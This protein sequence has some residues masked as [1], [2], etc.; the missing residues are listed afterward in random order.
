MAPF[1]FRFLQLA[2]LAACLS[3]PTRTQESICST[4]PELQVLDRS[5]FSFSCSINE[6]IH[7]L[8]CSGRGV[9]A[10]PQTSDSAVPAGI[11]IFDFS[12]NRIK[13]LPKVRWIDSG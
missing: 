2:L 4:A 7:E 8:N 13:C 9:P 10:L 11:E 3:G 1:Y 5:I 12:H 6:M